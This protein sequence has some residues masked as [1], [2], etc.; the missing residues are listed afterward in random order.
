MNLLI[1]KEIRLLLPAWVA[2]MLLAV[3]PPWILPLD[4]SIIH[5][6]GSLI[7]ILFCLGVLI[8]GITSFGQEF[9]SGAI[10]NLLA[11]PLDRNRIWRTKTAI[12]ALA[13][14]IVCF[15]AYASFLCRFNAA[16]SNAI[17]LDHKINGVA[18]WAEF[19][20]DTLE[21]LALSALVTFSG[22]L[23]TTLL[24][25]QMTA[26]FWFTLLIPVAIVVVITAGLQ[27]TVLSDATINRIMIAVLLAYSIAGFL[28]ARYLF[29]R[30]QDI[31]WSGGQITFLWRRK[32]FESIAIPTSDRSRHWFSSLFRKEIQLHQA[33][34]L[35]AVFLLAL[36]VASLCIL[37][38]HPHFKNPNVTFMLQ[39]VGV[40]WL[41]MPLVI[42]GTAIAEERRLATLEFHLC[43]PIS[44]RTQLIVK[45]FV[46][47]LLSLFLGGVMPLL[48]T[49]GENLHSWFAAPA[50]VIAVAAAIFF[51]SFYASS[52]A[53]TTVQAIGW[54]IIICLMTA[55]LLGLQSMPFGLPSFPP[56]GLGIL[57]LYWG[58]MVFLMVFG[59]MLFWNF[60]WLHQNR[61]VWVWNGTSVFLAFA[62]VVAFT[63]GT[64]YRA[65]EL[66]LPVQ[67]PAGL[68][69]IVNPTRI[70]MANS[71]NTLYIVT[72]DSRLWTDTLGYD[73]SIYH[74]QGWVILSQATSRAEFIGGT[75]WTDV[76]SD[77]FQALGVQ[78]DGTLWSIRRMWSEREAWWNQTGPFT[79]TRI[80][81]ASDW[82]EVAADS[83]GFLALKKDG[84]LWTWGTHGFNWNHPQS[85][86]KKVAMDQ[87]ELPVHIGGSETF[88]EVFAS[89]GYA[90]ARK[91][92][93]AVWH[94]TAWKDTNYV[95]TLTHETNLDNQWSN[96]TFSPADNLILGVKTNG[97][98]FV[99]GTIESAAMRT[100]AHY[101]EV[102]LGENRQ[103]KSAAYGRNGKI[104]AIRDD[105]TLWQWPPRWFLLNNPKIRPIQLGT[106][107]DWVALTDKSPE[108]IGLT[109]DG[110]VWAW[111]QPSRY[112]WLAPSRK[113]IYLGNIFDA[114]SGT[115]YQA[116]AE[117]NLS[118]RR[119]NRR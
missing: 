97:A 22:G 51:V 89:R 88:A 15:A 45:F 75:N 99:G 24:L 69:R 62:S 108:G 103:W 58:S 67:P 117:G 119:I 44:R 35:I 91:S 116:V 94:W 112:I 76:T 73:V 6:I 27:A 61:T 34:L 85:M 115:G 38:I 36:N 11:Q 39:A 72:P 59:F 57:T 66:F 107:S 52:F 3:V 9:N 8:L 110:C 98:L 17:I 83:I 60:D 25:R 48:M 71:V 70:S 106:H 40:L 82:S 92:T 20:L 49:Q 111:G 56:S 100:K 79:L 64:Y 81:S 46:G 16:F 18:F 13:F 104:L 43:L 32:T 113:P 77:R 29:L 50:T 86:A 54:A 101:V 65:W 19:R 105:G 26:A 10:S 87:A 96:F 31:Q 42:G 4:Y 68:V 41:L 2:A 37:K 1:K 109:T 30:A 23:W 90:Y 55:G 78:S 80:G 21:L 95:S 63:D 53:R 114:G 84:S 28:F 7:L 5:S 33:N 118:A 47:L 93:G 74:G 14:L 102:E 12:L